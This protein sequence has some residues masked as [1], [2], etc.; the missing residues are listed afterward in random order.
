MLYL[1]FADEGYIIRDILNPLLVVRRWT[2]EQHVQNSQEV[3][4]FAFEDLLQSQSFADE[5]YMR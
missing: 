2:T 3:M 4:S 1:R 5:G